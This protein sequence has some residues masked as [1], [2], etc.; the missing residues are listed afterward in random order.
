M[1]P[2]DHLSAMNEEISSNFLS[3]I[4]VIFK[5]DIQGEAHLTAR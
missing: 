1:I 3:Q 4:L 2:H 5:K